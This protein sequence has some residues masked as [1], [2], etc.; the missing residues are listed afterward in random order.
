MLYFVLDIVQSILQTLVWLRELLTLI[1]TPNGLSTTATRRVVRKVTCQPVRLLSCI[2]ILFSFWDP[3][4]AHADDVLSR[5]AAANAFFSDDHPYQYH[6]PYFLSARHGTRQSFLRIVWRTCRKKPNFSVLAVDDSGLSYGPI[7]IPWLPGPTG[8]GEIV[9]F[10]SEDLED[11]NPDK[12]LSEGI[13]P[14][15]GDWQLF[16]GSPS[17]VD[18]LSY[19]RTSDGFLTAMHDVVPFNESENAYVVR[20]FNPGRNVNQRSWLRLINPHDHP[21][22]VSVNAQHD[23]Q[24]GNSDYGPWITLS[25]H[26]VFSVDAIELET[27]H[28]EWT[29][30]DDTAY[31]DG[32]IGGTG[33]EVGK[34]RLELRARNAGDD[35]TSLNEWRDL[36]VMNLM[37]T[38]GGYLTNLSTVPDTTS[39]VVGDIERDPS[40]AFDIDLRWIGDVPRSV[41]R[42]VRSA[43]RRWQRIVTGELPDVHTTIPAEQC[44]NDEDVDASIDDVMVFVAFRNTGEANPIASATSCVHDDDTRGMARRPIVGWIRVNADASDDWSSVTDLFDAIMAHELGHV[45]GFTEDVLD[46]SGYLRKSPATHFAGP[47]AVEAFEEQCGTSYDGDPVPME[48]D[49][50]HWLDSALSGE[51][52]GPNIGAGSPISKITVQTLADLGYEVDENKAEPFYRTVCSPAVGAGLR[53]PLIHRSRANAA[54]GPAR[55]TPGGLHNSQDEAEQT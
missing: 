42:S 32:H 38:P 31:D 1:G 10:N 19:V 34:W 36:V 24:V 35:A 41:Q 30:P 16:I 5:S 26:Q 45:L 23:Q 2:G 54:D 3:A 8:C 47:K 29:R 50:A 55:H 53:W 18:V 6:V 21:V 12:G 27:P 44:L 13:G 20:T 22:H 17:S 28:P 40:V 39:I 48:N 25:A 4:D 51:I 43:A 49:A 15:D 37:D 11:G 9:K 52:M 7:E 33:N 14:G 46:A